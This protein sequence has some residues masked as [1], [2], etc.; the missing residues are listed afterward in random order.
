MV[1]PESEHFRKQ[2]AEV[3]QKEGGKKP[4]LRAHY[5]LGKREVTPGSELGKILIKGVN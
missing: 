3:W 1:C 4:S 2:R 5:S